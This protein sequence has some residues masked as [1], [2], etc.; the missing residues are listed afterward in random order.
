MAIYDCFQFFNEEHVLDLRINIL[1]KKLNEAKIINNSEIELDKHMIN[2]LSTEISISNREL[3]GALNRIISFSRVYKK[4]P[5]ISEAKVIL[6]KT[7]P[8]MKKKIIPQHG[9]FEPPSL[10]EL[11]TT[12][13]KIICEAREVKGKQIKSQVY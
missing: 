2:F 9:L 4:L 6:K 3:I 7:K 5:S 10:E 13:S 11:Q 8:I 1:N 12:L